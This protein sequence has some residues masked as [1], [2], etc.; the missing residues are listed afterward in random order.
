[1]HLLRT[2]LS[3]VISSL[4]LAAICSAQ[5]TST[6]SV[7]NLIRYGGTLKDAQGT[8]VSSATTGVT[9]AVYPQQDGGAPVWME[10]QNVTTDAGG[11]Y[12]V[13]LGS[14]TAAGLPADLFSQEEQRW[15]GVQVQ[16]Q[17]EQPRVLLVSV[18]YALKAH[19]AETLGGKTISDFVLAN[20]AISKDNNNASQAGSST[21]NPAQSTQPPI[22]TGGTPQGPTDFSGTTTDQ[23]VKVTQSGT[24]AGVNASAPTNAIFGMATAATGT[25]FGVQGSASGTGGIGLAGA[26][27]SPTGSTFGIKASASS[28]SG[29]GLRGVATATTGATFGVTGQVNSPA[30]TA[31]SFNNAGGG[32]ILSGQNNGVENFSVDG[33]GNV[34]S[35][36]K[37]TGSGSGLTGI[38]FSSLTGTLTSSQFSGTYSNAVTLSNTGNTFAGSSFTGGSFTGSSF[39]GSGAGLTGILFS[40]LSGT[41]GNAQFAGTYSNPVTLSSSTNSFTGSGAGLTGVLPAAG[42]PHYIQNTTSPETA[43]FNITGNGSLSGTLSAAAG[44][45]GT[46][47]TGAGNAVFGMATVASGTANGV[48]GQTASNGGNGVFGSATS[49]TGSADGVFGQSSST[50]GAGVYGKALAATGT[51]YGVAGS[52]VSNSGIGVYGV[53]TATTGLTNGVYGVDSSTTFNASGVFGVSTATSGLT[54]GVFGMNGSANGTAVYGDETAESGLTYGVF[55]QISSTTTNASAVYGNATATSGLTYGVTG[56]NVSTVGAGVY[57]WAASATGND[58]GI[59]GQ[60]DS[61]TDFASGVFGVATASTGQTYGVVGSTNSTAQNASGVYGNT[62][63]STG[64]GNGVFGSSASN[65]GTGVFGIATSTDTSGFGYGVYGQSANGDG[66]YGIETAV[67]GS[68]V[69]GMASSNGSGFTEGVT[70]VNAATSG[71]SNGVYGTTASPGGVGGL[72]ENT[73]GGL[74]LLARKNS[75]QSL[76]TID[77]SGNGFFAGAV[78]INGNLNVGGTL[79]KGGGSFKIDDPLDPAN[80]TLSHSFV[81]SPDMMNIYNGLIRLDAHGEAWVELPEYFEALNRD[82][83][84]QLTSVG[85]PQ[86]RLYIA[87][88]V[89]GNRFKIAGGKANAKVSWQLTGIRQDAWANAHR[90][91]VEEEKSEKERGTYLHPDLYPPASDKNTDA[92]LQH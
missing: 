23:I 33:S 89:K 77:G 4:L 26:A 7:P 61:N 44:L 20:G 1:M 64:N 14:T 80:K 46:I 87:R 13:L 17:P 63:A 57:G 29:T 48:Y 41:L 47:T 9:F 18:P 69:V 50:S 60:T 40:H 10:T 32:K 38:P 62:T 30:G 66:V 53:S 31:A 51:V 55:G 45:S 67:N 25:V 79:T 43:N 3:I 52:S 70:G 91:P 15:L 85:A 90:I 27:T 74:S 24:G 65:T 49:T 71:Y 73:G 81:E 6:T 19:E 88:E 35:A 28:T 36:G 68:G 16:G 54:N 58:S 2:T 86:P 84:Y 22:Q 75:S 42:S 34:T 76:F 12:S 59:V 92:M 83:R 21:T 78:Q 72:F 5:Q 8:A 37:F 82:F 39:T 11:N 56:K